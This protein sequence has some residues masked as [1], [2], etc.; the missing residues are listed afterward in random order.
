LVR[1]EGSWGP[2]GPNDRL[3]WLAG[4]LCHCL[5]PLDPSDPEPV[6]GLNPWERWGPAFDGLH[7]LTGFVGDFVDDQSGDFPEKF[8]ENILGTNGSPAQTIVEAWFNACISAGQ[9]VGAAM[10][11]INADGVCD[12][13]DYY[14]GKGTQGK[15]IRRQDITGWWYR[16]SEDISH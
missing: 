5:D 16:T 4:V 3:Y 1:Y 8:A 14:F 9:G 12:M 2:F 15:T 11:P 10:G 13:G 7:I 6:E